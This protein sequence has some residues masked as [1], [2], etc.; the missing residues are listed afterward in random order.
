MKAFYI[1]VRRDS[2]NYF[3]IEAESLAEAEQIA[4]DKD[5]DKLEDFSL[6]VDEYEPTW[7]I[8][9]TVTR[10]YSCY[11]DA[12]DEKQAEDRAS[13][14]WDNDDEPLGWEEI[15]DERGDNISIDVEL[16]E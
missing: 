16:C 1:R 4:I 14:S 9:K 13:Y 8:T 10:K 3:S 7:L 12:V 15:T 6:D 11:V 5:R 2:V